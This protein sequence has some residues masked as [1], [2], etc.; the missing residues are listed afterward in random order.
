[1]PLIF[2]RSDAESPIVYTAIEVTERQT[3]IEMSNLTNP[4][5]IVATT[6]SGRIIERLDTRITFNTTS[7]T[8]VPTGKSRIPFMIQRRAMSTQM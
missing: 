2:K 6:I 7:L 4:E 8:K 3:T 5:G 1:M